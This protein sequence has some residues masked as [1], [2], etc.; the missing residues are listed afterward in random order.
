MSRTNGRLLWAVGAALAVTATCAT[1]ADARANQPSYVRGCRID[2]V[3]A[4]A[5]TCTYTFRYSQTVETFVVPPTTEPVHI[6][7]VGAPGAGDRGY[8]S[9]GARVSGSFPNLGGMPIY[10]AVGGEGWFDGYNGGGPGGGGGASDVRLGVPDLQHRIMVAAGGGGW[11]EEVVFD[12]QA[13]EQRL[14]L[15]KGGD[16]GLPGSGSG[17]QPGTA[18]AG[19]IGGGTQWA[20][21]QPGRIGRGGAGAPGI[22]G[23][24]GGGLYGG[25]GGG[26]C[27]GYDAT[28]SLCPDSQPGSGGGGSSL[29]PPGGTSAVS[30][31]FEPRVVITVVQYAPW[32]LP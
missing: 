32:P 14:R 5:R 22:N 21:G 6:L 16:A 28:G 30:D 2:S 18:T 7:A 8:R 17:G 26:G 20:Q 25:G 13:G 3:F 24:G 12:D 29:I 11:G 27:S 15:I 4:G 10:V 9:L 23:G 31:D 1:P 19:G